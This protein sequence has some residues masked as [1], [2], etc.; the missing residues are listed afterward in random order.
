[1]QKLLLFFIKSS[2]LKS[3]AFRCNGMFEPGQHAG[4]KEYRAGLNGAVTDRHEPQLN[5]VWTNKL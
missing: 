3:R 2:N 5:L 1:M 4:N